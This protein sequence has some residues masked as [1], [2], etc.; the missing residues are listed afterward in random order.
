MLWRGAKG[1]TANIDN[2]YRAIMR[3]GVQFAGETRPPRARR[4]PGKSS[5]L[6][7]TNYRRALAITLKEKGNILGKDEWIAAISRVDVYNS[8]ASL[9]RF[10]LFC[11]SDDTVADVDNGGLIKAGRPGTNPMLT[12]DR[13]NDDAYLT[14][15]HIA[16]QSKNEGWREDI[17]SNPLLVN[18]LGNLTLLPQPE[19]EMLGSKRW[20]HK[21]A[22]Y[23][24][25]TSKT[26]EEFDLQVATLQEIGLTLGK[27]AVTVLSNARYL[28]MCESIAMVEDEWSAQMI[29]E[30]TKCLAGLAWDR[31]ALWLNL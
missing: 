6:S 28:G 10:L 13:W 4:P 3:T 26:Q 15:E 22:V 14:I 23:R 8:S 30:R 27:D 31:L 12:L 29:E 25:L 16:P 1:G 11:A 5:E 18:T 2:H 9:A 19:N 7:L 21:Q 24:L 17:Y 20:S